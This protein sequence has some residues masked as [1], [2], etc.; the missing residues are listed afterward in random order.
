MKYRLLKFGTQGAKTLFWCAIGLLPWLSAAATATELRFDTAQQW[1]QWQMPQRAVDLSPDGRI[2]PLRVNKN[3]NAALNALD[4]GG[5]IRSASSNLDAATRVIDGDASTGWRPAPEETSTKQWIE[6]DLGR[7]VSARR[8]NLVFASETP[9]FELFDLLL[10]TGEP[11]RS[12]A[13]T[14][15]PGTIV[16]RIRERFKENRRHRVSLELE[17][18]QP[19]LIQLVRLELLR[20]PATAE[21][22]EV[23]V[24]SIGD[25]LALGALENGGSLDILLSGVNSIENETSLLGIILAAIDGDMNTAWANNRSTRADNDVIGN[26]TLDLGAVYWLDAVRLVSF[27]SLRSN[28]RR[29][30][31]NFYEIMTSDGSLAP[32][33]TP[34][35]RKQFSGWPADISRRQGLADHEF[36]PIPGQFLRISWKRWD[37]HCGTELGNG[38]TGNCF[39][40]GVTTE[41]QVF[42]EGY[43]AQVRLLS[44]I[45]D[46]GGAKN[47][48]A[49]RWDAET[50]PGTRVEIH[51]RSGHSLDA[52]VVFRDK[53]GKQV[54]EKRWKKLIPNFR[55]QIDTTRV[56]AGDW[57][58]WS[59]SYQTSGQEFLS[60]SLRRY[61]E[62]DVRLISQSAQRAAALNQVSL[63][64]SEPLATNVV[65][66]ISPTQVEPGR[67]TP[68]SYYVRPISIER[69]F[70]RL[71]LEASVPMRFTE[72]RL[73]GEPVAVEIDAGDAG[74]KVRFPQPV[75]PG[76][77]V[78]LRFAAAVFMDATRFDLFLENSRLLENM[79]QRVEPGDASDAVES[80]AQV[81]R[82]PLGNRLF[83]HLSVEPAVLTPNGDGVNDRLEVKFD[84]V[85]VLE[86]RPLRLRL[87]DLSGRRVHTLMAE[88]AAGSWRLVWD[89]RQNGGM[90]VPPGHYILRL[91]VEGDA[92]SQ[93]VTRLVQVIY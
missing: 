23:E 43:P 6:V 62:L 40:S 31:F 91:S 92:R 25:N 48:Y 53:D 18:S 79:R 71:A 85:N 80:S 33:G 78:E 16:Y 65:A 87:F 34:A 49:L 70:D 5:G 20:A 63:D 39:A 73:N 45:L 9:P 11:I 76:E 66:E 55:G 52:Q 69:G 10:S 60:P 72:A 3:I 58:S 68:F 86:R 8:I 28:W 83:T 30:G 46:L 19:V 36:A 54:T 81:V 61:V 15:V 47:I 56:P 27:S 32:D 4:F 38:Q 21:L 75:R 88:G 2:R 24:E 1:R 77:L 57:S 50:P 29:Y 51:S 82:L 90:L 12:N 42:G 35:W 14:P 74:F 59:A 64:F 17:E 13:G 44:P 89:G 93:S 41:L 84:L 26:M 22:V 67:E 7:A 37:A